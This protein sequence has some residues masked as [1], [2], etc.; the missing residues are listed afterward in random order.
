MPGDGIET[1]TTTAE[2]L[3]SRRTYDVDELYHRQSEL[4]AYL[5]REV[6]YGTNDVIDDVTEHMSHG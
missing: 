1:K 6:A 4:D 2:Q 5:L 3:Q